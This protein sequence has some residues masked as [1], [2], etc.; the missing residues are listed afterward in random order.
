MDMRILLKLF[1]VDLFVR[2]NDSLLYL[3]VCGCV[4]VCMCADAK[5]V[6]SRYHGQLWVPDKRFIYSGTSPPGWV[7]Q[8]MGRV[9]SCCLVS[10]F[11]H[12]LSCAHTCQHTALIWQALALTWYPCY[13][14]LMADWKQKVTFFY[15]LHCCLCL[16]Q[17]STWNL[18]DPI[19]DLCI[20]CTRFDM[21]VYTHS[22]AQAM[23]S[24][25]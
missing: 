11:M 18:K 4:H 9:W 20:P 25:D 7:C 10:G 16:H 3:S 22:K 2:S 13:Q 24:V 19:K 17:Y 6:C 21:L 15:V 1:W 14:Y 23:K 5:S 8:D 12:T